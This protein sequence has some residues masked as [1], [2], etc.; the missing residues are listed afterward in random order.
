MRHEFVRLYRE[1]SHCELKP[2]RPGLERLII[3]GV[4]VPQHGVHDEIRLSVAN[5]AYDF[6][7]AEDSDAQEHQNGK[8]RTQVRLVGCLPLEIHID[9]LPE[10]VHLA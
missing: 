7:D 10:D 9:A 4:H 1:K 6:D 5:K 8:Y 3:L 2:I